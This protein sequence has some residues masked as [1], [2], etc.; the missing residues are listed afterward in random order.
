[1]NRFARRTLKTGPSMRFEHVDV[2]SVTYFGSPQAGSFFRTFSM[3][4]PRALP[5]D[6]FHFN[7]YSAYYYCLLLRL[8]ESSAKLSNTLD[9]TEFTI[10]ASVTSKSKY[11]ESK[12]ISVPSCERK[13]A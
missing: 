1:M 10:M 3:W 11:I 2:L 7:S 5:L 6:L 8:L 9:I 12:I 13:Q 4:T